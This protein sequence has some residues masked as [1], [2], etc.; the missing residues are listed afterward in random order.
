[1][2]IIHK[3]NL[4]NLSYLGIAITIP[5]FGLSIGNIGLPTFGF[6]FAVILQLFLLLFMKKNFTNNNNILLLLVYFMIIFISTLT[7]ISHVS[8]FKEI[9][10]FGTIVLFILLMDFSKVDLNRFFKYLMVIFFIRTSY[11]LI[12]SFTHLYEWIGKAKHFMRFSVANLGGDPN[13]LAL[14]LIAPMLYV[15]FFYRGKL[16]Y[17]L[18]IP[19]LIHFIM[20]YSRGAILALFLSL[21]FYMLYFKKVKIFKYIL[22]GSITLIYMIYFLYINQYIYFSLDTF[23]G[24]DNSASTRL[25][26]WKEVLFDTNIK[27]AIFGN[28]P[29][30]FVDVYGHWLHNSYVARYADIGVVGLLVYVTILFS[31]LFIFLKQ[32]SVYS[33]LLLSFIIGSFFV[34]FYQNALMW[35]L[36][37]YALKN[38]IYYRKVKFD[39]N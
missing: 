14:L 17:F 15:L 9:V 18:F 13:N 21:I 8:S 4:N 34:D 7:S 38:S 2:K 27:Q 31:S 32:R 36:I 30:T 10:S 35:F 37:G 5:M 39:E 23:L 3:V 20:L 11:E 16:K 6:L 33:I 28:G 19:F 24:N 25:L 22:L 1:M 29:R 12:Y 26:Y